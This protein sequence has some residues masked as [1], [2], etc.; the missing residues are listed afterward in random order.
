M[1]CSRRG[2]LHAPAG[3][4]EGPP[5]T[6]PGENSL[7]PSRRPAENSLPRPEVLMRPAPRSHLSSVSLRLP[8]FRRGCYSHLCAGRGTLRRAAR[9]LG[10]GSLQPRPLWA[11]QVFIPRPHP[12]RGSQPVRSSAECQRRAFVPDVERCCWAPHQ[13]CLA[14][15]P[16]TG[17]TTT[18]Q[19]LS[20]TPVPSSLSITD[21]AFPPSDFPFVVVSASVNQS[22]CPW[23]P[24]PPPILHTARLLLRFK[25][26]SCPTLCF[27]PFLD[28]W[29]LTR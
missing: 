29:S 1:A 9:S 27:H 8:W 25:F 14:S 19:R 18:L 22:H 23:S 13:P 10:L 6:H 28:A 7:R 26:K 21:V 15:P 24:F 3:Q 2:R 5:S 11:C 4:R 20:S 17:V 16:F 12:P